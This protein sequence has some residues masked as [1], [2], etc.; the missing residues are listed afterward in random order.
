M[1]AIK[2]DPQECHVIEEGLNKG[3]GQSEKENACMGR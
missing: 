2:V 1:I 3:T